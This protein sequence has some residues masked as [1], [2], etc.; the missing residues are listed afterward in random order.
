MKCRLLIVI[1]ALLLATLANA[2]S[3]EV[4]ASAQAEAKTSGAPGAASNAAPNPWAFSLTTSGYIV[5]GGPNYL[6]PDFTAD[7]SWL[8]LEG[9]YNSEALETGSLWVGRNFSA[10]KKL[11]L[12]VTP[13][14]GGVFGSLNGVAPGFLFALTYKQVQLYSS[15]EY[16]IDTQN[17]NDNFFYSW[18]QLTYSPLKWLQVGLVSQRTRVYHTSL[19]VQRGVLVGVTYKKV[20]FTTNIFNF[21]W[22]TPTEVLQLGLNF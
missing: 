3:P 11:V 17:R 9:R 8:H 16:V 20:N 22:T 6:S 21:G 14:F 7:R 1:G 19:D 2:Q 4:P 10:G 13:M 5:P 18:N 12:N 15:G